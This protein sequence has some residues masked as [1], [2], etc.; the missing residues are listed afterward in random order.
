MLKYLW[1]FIFLVGCT[2]ES[3]KQVSNDFQQIPLEAQGSGEFGTVNYGEIKIKSFTFKNNEPQSVAVAPVLEGLHSADFS[4]G[5][6][7]GCSQIE[8][9]KSCLVKVVFNSD[10]KTA[11]SYNANLKVG[12]NSYPLSAQ[13]A[14]VPSV[15]YELSLNTQKVENT[16][17]LPNIVTN[18]LRIYSL[19]LK[20][21]SPIIANAGTLTSTNSFYNLMANSCINKLLKPS[22]SCYAKLVIKGDDS[23]EVKSTTLN[24]D[25][26]SFELQTENQA[27]VAVSSFSATTTSLELGDFYGDGD[28]VI[29]AIALQNDGNGAGSVEN[30][31]LPPDYRVLTNN[32]SGV[33]PGNKCVIRIV[34]SSPEQPVKGQNS[35]SLN[36]GGAELEVI[37]NQVNKPSDL[38]NIILTT[39]DNILVNECKAL[40]VSMKDIEGLDY[41]ISTDNTFSINQTLFQDSNCQTEALSKL[42]PFESSKTFYIKS[43]TSGNKTL[44]LLKND[45]TVT[46]EVYFYNPLVIQENY[47][48]L[49]VN[50]S[51]PIMFAGGKP[52]HTI[53]VLSGVG[54]LVNGSFS[55]ALA[56]AAQIKVTDAL[57]NNGLIDIQ[58]V[59]VLTANVKY[60]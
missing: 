9:G 43:L 4:I 33:K 14:S 36:L 31:T 56:G 10:K 41:V 19:K 15:K 24:F 48:N 32:C 60:L 49:I 2:K 3:S 12:D 42:A 35:D 52:P 6:T 30:I 45:K 27:Q 23:N 57:G 1:I 25:G 37:S 40:T 59:S 5:L 17:S 38:G 51:Y 22:E 54:A 29:K 16:L 11:G 50:Q 53:E 28:Q 20:N 7:L 58:V 44:T 39:L 34:Y 55:S 47:K 46:K 13:I 18:E 26:K 21:N 8:T